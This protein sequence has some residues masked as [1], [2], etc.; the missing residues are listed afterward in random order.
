MTETSLLQRLRSVVD[1][2]DHWR[3][4]NR[5]VDI[6]C[7][8]E[9]FGAFSTRRARFLKALARRCELK[10]A[11]M[12]PLPVPL[13]SGF[14]VDGGLAISSRFHASE[15]HW[16]G[17]SRGVDSDALSQ[18]GV[19]HMRV[20]VPHT[21]RG[22]QPDDKA[23][24]SYIPVDVFTTHLQSDYSEKSDN[25]PNRQTRSE[26]VSVLAAF[27]QQHLSPRAVGVI[28][29]DFNIDKMCPPTLQSKKD[30]TPGAVADN[31]S[32]VS[33]EFRV[34]EKSL[35][36]AV[37][38][39]HQLYDV[40]AGQC[41]PTVGDVNADGTSRETRLTDATEQCVPKC[42]DHIFVLEPLDRSTTAVEC[43]EATVEHLEVCDHDLMTYLPRTSVL[44]CPKTVQVEPTDPLYGSCSQLSDHYGCSVVLH[45]R[46][47]N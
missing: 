8:Q 38:A 5:Q 4:I 43:K 14:A 31:L 13:F 22:L 7:L 40:F 6:V 32:P 39:T 20:Q 44:T 15:T 1:R 28:C 42:V 17:Y 3:T 24:C 16:K 9:L 18:K 21:Q 2:L 11:F 33:E 34:L 41:T 30:D 36:D 37:A 25:T 47:L 12:C 10:C 27:V 26:Q 23:G 46:K 35:R 45:L 29:G 19:I